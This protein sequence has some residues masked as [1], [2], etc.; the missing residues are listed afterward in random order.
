MKNI[1]SKIPS[2]FTLIELLV[3]VSIISMLAT[4]ILTSTKMLFDK[5]KDSA[6]RYNMA[7]LLTQASIYTLNTGYYDGFCADS[8][9]NVFISEINKLAPSSYAVL[10]SCNT[11]SCPAGAKATTWCSSIKLN[12]IDVAYKNRNFVFCVDSTGKKIE[13]AKVTCANGSCVMGI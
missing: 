12:R 1:K 13:S 3:V 8:S 10:C 2:G 9:A 7:N 11:G 4:I 6:I 5:G